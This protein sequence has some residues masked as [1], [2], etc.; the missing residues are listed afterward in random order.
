MIRR[1]ALGILQMALRHASP[2]AQEWGQ[3]MLRELDF[4]KGDWAALRWSVGSAAS[5]FRPFD[6][7]LDS[8]VGV[9]A[10][11]RSLMEKTRKRTIVG[12]AACLIVLA[13]SVRNLFHSFNRP[14][15]IG[16]LVDHFYGSFFSRSAVPGQKRDA[17]GG[18]GSFHQRGFLSEGVGAAEKFSS[19]YMALL[20]CAHD[21]SRLHALVFRLWNGTSGACA[22]HAL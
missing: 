7:P 1:L 18:S 6:V 22:H 13:W 3:A 17:F 2:R 11:T 8:P 9:A 14:Q 4:V 15:L 21:D 5:L 16:K 12:S 19:R 10:M 20:T